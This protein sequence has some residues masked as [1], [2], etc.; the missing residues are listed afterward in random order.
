[1]IYYYIVDQ[2]SDQHILEP[3]SQLFSHP[4]HCGQ[5]RWSDHWIGAPG[6]DVGVLWHWSRDMLWLTACEI[7]SHTNHGFEDQ[8]GQVNTSRIR[9]VAPASIR[10]L[11]SFSGSWLLTIWVGHRR[12][13]TNEGHTHDQSDLGHCIHRNF[14]LGFLIYSLFGF[15]AS[16]SRNSLSAWLATDLARRLFS[17]VTAKVFASPNGRAACT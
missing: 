5:A 17:L 6:R 1:V 12:T 14:H 15:C 13:T 2:V 9:T 8:S 7:V 16:N 3:V 10:D 11:L 4:I